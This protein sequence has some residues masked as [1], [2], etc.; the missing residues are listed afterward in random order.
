M[1]GWRMSRTQPCKQVRALSVPAYARPA[2]ADEGLTCWQVKSGVTTVR[3]TG[4]RDNAFDP[5]RLPMKL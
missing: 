3:R 4:I 5:M 1:F 2:K